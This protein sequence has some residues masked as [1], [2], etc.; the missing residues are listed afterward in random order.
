MIRRAEQRAIPVAVPQENAVATVSRF[1]YRSRGVL[2]A[3]AIIAA[4]VAAWESPPAIAHLVTGAAVLLVGWS[5][6]IWAQRH[7]G[8]RLR[9]HRKRLTTCGPYRWVR[10]PIYIANTLVV[11]GTTLATGD[12]WLAAAAVLLCCIV[13]SLTVHWE[14]RALA[15]WYGDRYVE[16]ARVTPRWIPSTPASPAVASCTGTRRWR[17]VAMAEWHVPLILV[18]V[19]IPL[20]LR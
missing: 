13:Y 19:L 1:A 8:Y 15:R 10:N 9:H 12:Y 5:G 7:L 4:T 20:V 16:Y 17:D 2:V 18:P 3:P 14:E 6:R 11:T